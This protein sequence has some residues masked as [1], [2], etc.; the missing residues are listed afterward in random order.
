MSKVFKFCDGNMINMFWAIKL[1]K[2][3]LKT[4]KVYNFQMSNSAFNNYNN[5]NT[6]KYEQEDLASRI[7]SQDCLLQQNLWKEQT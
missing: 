7:S 1:V 4:F 6:V 2:L 3:K 5:K